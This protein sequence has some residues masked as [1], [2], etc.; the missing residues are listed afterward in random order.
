MSPVRK[1]W[2]GVIFGLSVA[3]F[4]FCSIAT[5]AHAAEAATYVAQQDD[6]FW[7]VSNKLHVP[8]QSLLDANPGISPLNVYPGLT[9]QLPAA[10]APH[11]LA[12]AGAPSLKMAKMAIAAPASAEPAVTTVSGTS[13]AYSRTVSAVASAYTDTPAE[14]GS[15]GN[16]DYY[17]NAL[18]LGTV[19]VDP[20]VI[21]L[22]SKL[23]ITGYTFD[24]IPSGIVATASDIGGA[25]KGNRVDIFIPSSMG[26]ASN[27][28][29]QNVTVYLLK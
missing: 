12:A 11:T 7:T 8:L 27:F 23:Y 5:P 9:L 21:P 17:G 4:A 3:G 1:T 28:G 14:N 18:K 19:A 25:I 2:A 22:G 10:V 13:L 29:L 16:V 24:G 15:W 6:T 20:N 26:D